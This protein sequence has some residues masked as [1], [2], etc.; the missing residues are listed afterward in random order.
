MLKLTAYMAEYQALGYALKASV[1]KIS[2]FLSV[3]L[4]I[5]LVMG[6]LMCMW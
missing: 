1:R 6:T 2:V 5:I 4:M 3:V